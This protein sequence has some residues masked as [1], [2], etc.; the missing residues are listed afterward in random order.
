[1]WSM[2]R[3]LSHAVNR[4]K[5]TCHWTNRSKKLYGQFEKARGELAKASNVEVT[6]EEVVD[7]MQ[8][9]AKQVLDLRA[10]LVM[11]VNH[12]ELISNNSNEDLDHDG[13]GIYGIAKEVTGVD[14][15]MDVPDLTNVKMNDWEKI[16]FEAWLA[17]SS[18]GWATRIAEEHGYSR[19]APQIALERVLARIHKSVKMAA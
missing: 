4:N 15:R 13:S 10:M 9:T 7:S 11:V 18:R 17:D 19:R 16:V 6:F 2:K 1:V 8:L 14:E 5:P 12:S 3:C